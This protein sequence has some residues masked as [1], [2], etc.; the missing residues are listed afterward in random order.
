MN[1][2]LP[3]SYVDFLS[4]I[5]AGNAVILGNSVCI[6]FYMSGTSKDLK[7]RSKRRNILNNQS[8][9]VG[10]YF[11][12][13]SE[14]FAFV[15]GSSLLLSKYQMFEEMKVMCILLFIVLF[16]E[17]TKEL[18]RT[19]KGYTIK[20]LLLHFLLLL[21]LVFSCSLLKKSNYNRLGN[22][23]NISHPYV[24]IPK[25]LDTVSYENKVLRSRYG[26]YCDIQ[27]KVLHDTNTIRYKLFG[28]EVSFD[29]L[30]NI[31]HGY[32]CPYSRSKDPEFFIYADGSIQYYQ[33][34]ELEQKA[35]LRGM[36]VVYYAIHAV[37]EA[38]DFLY[39]KFL[40]YTKALDEVRE[41]LKL[42]PLP[43][44]V[45]WEDYLKDKKEQVIDLD[46]FILK[47]NIDQQKVSDYFQE[48]VSDSVYFKIKIN[49]EITLQQ[50][51]DFMISYRQSVYDLRATQNLLNN[52]LQDFTIDV[53]EK[54]PFYYIEEME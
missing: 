34:K 52:E 18:R 15:A 11:F 23:Y 3:E 19:F 47:D 33:L 42:P 6:A 35:T 53:R 24:S 16:L 38:N 36:Y 17:S 21:A 31:P 48:S 7:R 13:F 32:D 39:P 9:L 45:F 30:I 12:W 25:T 22:V 1:S 28:N 10:N 8:F 50:Y 37:N 14:V 26:N 5:F 44:T 41:E 4:F 46:T 27:V 29:E 51:L 49:K 2:I 54:Y 43:T 20:I 40:H